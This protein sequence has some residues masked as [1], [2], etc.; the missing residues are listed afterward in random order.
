MSGVLL[1][2]LAARATIDAAAVSVVTTTVPTT[3][4]RITTGRAYATLSATATTLATS[5][6]ASSRM[7]ERIPDG[8]Q[9]R[10]V[11]RLVP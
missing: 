7:L 1:L 8:L 6:A 5:V 9:L 11:P 10:S 2:P 3:A 4:A